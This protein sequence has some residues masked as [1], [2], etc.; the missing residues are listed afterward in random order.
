MSIWAQID[1]TS[2]H[3]LAFCLGHSVTAVLLLTR[4]GGK[5]SSVA[6]SDWSRTSATRSNNNVHTPV[7][8]Q[9]H[10]PKQQQPQCR[11]AYYT[12]ARARKQPRTHSFHFRFTAGL[13]LSFV[14]AHYYFFNS[15]NNPLLPLRLALPPL[16][17]HKL[18][19]SFVL[20]L[21]QYSTE[22]NVGS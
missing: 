3:S 7:N 22:I 17:S 9:K 13:I 18:L 11:Y 8:T 6:G 20:P 19:F 21:S 1:A 15:N 4:G 10:A 14:R 12:Q 2:C 16:S 5:N